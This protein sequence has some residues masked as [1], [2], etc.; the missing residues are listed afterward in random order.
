MRYE[1]S[2]A[3]ITT[4][5]EPVVGRARFSFSSR[6]AERTA[7]APFKVM[8]MAIGAT[9]RWMPT[10]RHDSTVNIRVAPVRNIALANAF[11]S[12]KLPYRQRRE[13]RPL[14]MP[15]TPCRATAVVTMRTTPQ[16][17]MGEVS[18]SYRIHRVNT[19]AMAH[20]TESTR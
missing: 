7:T 19:I 20:I 15:N 13:Y 16:F 18:K 3:P 11:T 12:S 5:G 9:D 17:M 2:P 10:G 6:H 1:S 8:A 14:V 4:I